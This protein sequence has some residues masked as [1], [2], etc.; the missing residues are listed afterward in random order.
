MIQENMIQYIPIYGLI[1][2]RSDSDKKQ[3]RYPFN[4][5]PDIWRHQLSRG[6]WGYEFGRVLWGD[7]NNEWH[8]SE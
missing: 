2:S 7:E 8:F 1:I 3:G 6:D 4:R 5:I